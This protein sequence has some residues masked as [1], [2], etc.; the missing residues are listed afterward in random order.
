MKSMYGTRDAAQHGEEFDAQ[1]HIDMGCDQGRASTCVFRHI[2]RGI[3]VVMHGDD[4]AALGN[5]DGRDKYEHALAQHFEIQL[6]GAWGMTMVTRKSPPP[7]PAPTIASIESSKTR[8]DHVE[9]YG[10]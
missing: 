10:G 7:M 3:V 5:D 4:F 6:R 8:S 1:T 2:E 9:D